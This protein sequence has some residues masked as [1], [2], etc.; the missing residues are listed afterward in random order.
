MEQNNEIP[1]SFADAFILSKMNKMENLCMKI[2]DEW[3]ET[4]SDINNNGLLP[5]LN[6][7]QQTIIIG[8]MMPLEMTFNAEELFYAWSGKQIFI[9][10]RSNRYYKKDTEYTNYDLINYKGNWKCFLEKI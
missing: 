1:K 6:V 10:T 9:C 5:Q 8:E 4:K 2:K 3:W 7:E